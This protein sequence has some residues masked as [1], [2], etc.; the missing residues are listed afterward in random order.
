[1]CAGAGAIRDIDGIGRPGQGFC[2]GEKIGPVARGWR[3]DLGGHCKPAGAQAVPEPIR[4]GAT[5]SRV[6]FWHWLGK[7]HRRLFCSEA[8]RCDCC[9]RI[10]AARAGVGRVGYEPIAKPTQAGSSRQACPLRYAVTGNLPCRYWRTGSARQPPVVR[11][12]RE[13][14]R[15]CH[16][17][18]RQIQGRVHGPDW[19]AQRRSG[20]RHANALRAPSVRTTP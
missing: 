10:S 18:T 6:G 13:R 12:G 15:A 11:P 5:H 19:S 14:W 16:V 2:L 8:S 20:M 4:A 7:G 3:N 1:M 9:Q 17:R